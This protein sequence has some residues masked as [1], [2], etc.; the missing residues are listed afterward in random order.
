MS[1]KD[2][3]TLLDLEVLDRDLF[4]GEPDGAETGRFALY[5]GQVAA[6]SSMKGTPRRLQM[7]MAS[8]NVTGPVSP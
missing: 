2:L 5:G 3:A 4:R 8:F 7:A 1:R 6:P